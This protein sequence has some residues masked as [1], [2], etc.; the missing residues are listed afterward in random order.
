MWDM[1]VDKDYKI[2]NDNLYYV[3]L[4]IQEHIHSDINPHGDTIL[5]EGKIT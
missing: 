3:N 5:A 2:K 4:P 1:S